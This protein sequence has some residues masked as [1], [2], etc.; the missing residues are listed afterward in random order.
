MLGGLLLGLFESL[1]QGYLSGQWSDLFVFAILI[2]MMIV[3]PTG[4]LGKAD[5]RKV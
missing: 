3:R 2:V 1:T 4:L 5:I